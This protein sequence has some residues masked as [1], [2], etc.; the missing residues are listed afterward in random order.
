MFTD[1]DVKAEV[2][3]PITLQVMA[4]DDSVELDCALHIT[5]NPEPSIFSW[6]RNGTEQSEETSHRLNLTPETAGTKE[7]VMC[8]ADNSLG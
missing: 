7:T 2:E 1:I 5:G 4:G 8:T 3:N 6:I